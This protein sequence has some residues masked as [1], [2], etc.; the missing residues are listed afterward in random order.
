MSTLPS[1]GSNCST[2]SWAG[3]QGSS[4]KIRKFHPR[5]SSQGQALPCSLPDSW[6]FCPRQGPSSGLTITE[7]LAAFLDQALPVWNPKP[8]RNEVEP[9][10]TG[11]EKDW[12]FRDQPQ[13]KT[14][15]L[16]AKEKEVRPCPQQWGAH[17]TVVGKTARRQSERRGFEV[18]I[19]IGAHRY[20][21]ACKKCALRLICESS[22]FLIYTNPYSRFY[23][24]PFGKL[25]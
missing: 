18:R 12:D 23:E 20:S 10:S 7:N 19:V 2:L 14:L 17:P 16:Q 11:K 13:K 25:I 3:P 21:C 22:P 24:I 4:L 9:E 1:R 6:G 8:S 15:C 5:Q